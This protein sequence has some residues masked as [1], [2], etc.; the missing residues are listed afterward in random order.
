MVLDE[1][2]R[3]YYVNLGNSISI[4]D[5]RKISDINILSNQHAYLPL[6]Q[7]YGSFSQGGQYHLDK[8]NFGFYSD[9]NGNG[10]FSANVGTHFKLTDKLK[11]KTSI[12]TM[13]ENTTWLG[14][15]SD[16]VF[17][18][19]KDNVTNFGQI[20]AE[21][22]FGSNKISFDYYR[23]KTNVNTANNSL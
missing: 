21:Y 23:G 17:S 1:Y 11:L 7:M 3:D 16:G 13:S 22:S 2:E 12:G 6:Q 8:I 4:K 19:G 9:E 20:G 10:D 18:V 5:T 15:S 14:N